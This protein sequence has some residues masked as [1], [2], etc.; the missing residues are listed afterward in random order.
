MRGE[1]LAGRTFTKVAFRTFSHHVARLVVV[2]GLTAITSA[3]VTGIGALP[4][5]MRDGIERAIAN[6]MSPPAAA[7]DM[8]GIDT[9]S[10]AVAA[11]GS[12]DHVLADLWGGLLFVA[13]G[14]ER[15]SVVFP[16][17][18][19]TVAG[20]VI[21]MTVT[22]MVAAE[23]QQIGCLVT[24]GYSP[25]AVATRYLPFT[26]IG[27]LG[28]GIVGVA[29][30]YWT[31]APV[32]YASVQDMYGLPDAGDFLP[33]LGVASAVA[34]V[35]VM[36]GVTVWASASAA[37][38]TPARLLGARVPRAGARTMWERIPALWG[39][40]PYRYKSTVRNIVRYK[41]RFVM[42][43]TSMALA[44]VLVF[45]G[46][47]L[48]SVLS[49]EQPAL[50]DTIAPIS[51]MLVVAAVL[52]NALVVHNVTNINIE[53]REREIATLKVLGYYPHE[54][55]GY[56]FR[57]IAILTTIGMAM[58]L[59]LGHLVTRVLFAYLEFGN[60]SLLDAWVWP[61]AAALALASLGIADLLLYRKLIGVDM[62]TSLKV[63][64]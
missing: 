55:A 43:V 16:A 57:E 7:L 48:S 39:R 35:V 46:L 59:P 25:R 41:V 42:T 27:C 14:V 3:L 56:V 26:V 38:E 61:A 23:R 62:N 58:G 60:I 37:K 13:D 64:D 12:P 36:A 18:F 21:Y 52:L 40:L 54:V 51:A 30:G 19:F 32:L 24:L 53:E 15:I 22:R 44:T 33:G 34:T 10:G 4:T 49:H 28:G 50:M 63:V 47:A 6:G 29:A 45:A 5:M 9:G 8:I 31:V 20:L 17:L 1:Q 2:A 11:P